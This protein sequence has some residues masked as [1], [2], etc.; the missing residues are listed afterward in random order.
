MKHIK[1]IAEAQTRELGTDTNV[2]LRNLNHT[3]AQ[4]QQVFNVCNSLCRYPRGLVMKLFT[5]HEGTQAECYTQ[6]AIVKASIDENEKRFTK[7]SMAPMM[8][9]QLLQD[10]G[11]RAKR[12]LA[13]KLLDGQFTPQGTDHYITL[14]L[15][16]LWIAKAREGKEPISPIISTEAHINSWRRVKKVKSSDPH[17]LSAAH[18]VAGIKDEKIAEYDSLLRSIPSQFGFTPQACGQLQIAQS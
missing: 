2:E 10:I 8:K 12:D 17:E 13:C 3:E 9:G 6:P 16:H 4:I 7:A 15:Q 18:Y 5:Q 1:D 14:L 11:I